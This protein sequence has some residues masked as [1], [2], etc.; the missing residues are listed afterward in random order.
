MTYRHQMRSGWHV[1]A[2]GLLLAGIGSPSI[3]NANPLPR[4]EVFGAGPEDHWLFGVEMYLW[5]AS[6]G[7][8]TASGDDIDIGFDELV[9]DLK[10]G[11]MG[12]VAASRAQWTL[13]S[14]V[15]YLDVEDDIRQTIVLDDMSLRAAASID[16]K[17]F[18]STTGGAVRVFENNHS[19]L[20]V[21]AGAR[22]LWL[23]G[24][25]D[26]DLESFPRVKI[27]DTGKFWDGIV[28]LRGKSDISPRWYLTYVADIGA[29]DSDFTWQALAALNY[30]CRRF[31][32]VGGYRYL[33]WDFDNNRVFSDVNFSGVF[34]GIKLAF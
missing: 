28:G 4:Y 8:E 27:T 7:G 12:T 9:E 11:L 5:G 16:L 2:A 31:D 23:D 33:D 29:G 34:A 3:T 14:D 15:I 18:V 26:V 25:I 30:K 24:T 22:Y 13:F 20:N 19:R 10:F 17:G 32:I 6:V 1:L 21:M